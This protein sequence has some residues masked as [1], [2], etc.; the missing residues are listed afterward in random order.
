MAAGSWQAC[1]YLRRHGQNIRSTGRMGDMWQRRGTATSVGRKASAK[2][3]RWVTHKGAG[4]AEG[5]RACAFR[6]RESC[7][8]ERAL[9]PSPRPVSHHDS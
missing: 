1:R 9:A 4:K 2:S 8:I 7:L 3:A 6:G 5:V